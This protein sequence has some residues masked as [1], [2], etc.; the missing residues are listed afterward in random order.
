M[1]LSHAFACAG[2]LGG[3]GSLWLPSG[4]SG[5]APD[6]PA[7]RPRV[8]FPEPPDLLLTPVA[9]LLSPPQLG[10]D[11]VVLPSSDDWLAPK[12]IASAADLLPLTD[13]SRRDACSALGLS[14]AILLQ[15]GDHEVVGLRYQGAFF[16][17]CRAG[18]DVR[19][20]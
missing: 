12:F 9:L 17:V 16:S 1:A 7:G 13:D 14:E 11:V 4:G 3:H 19:L 18:L 5:S 8:F 15:Q 6:S 20:G 10:M 2:R